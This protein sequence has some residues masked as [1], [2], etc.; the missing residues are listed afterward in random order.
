MFYEYICRKSF[1]FSIGSMACHMAHLR[2]VSVLFSVD[3]REGKCEGIFNAL[4]RI[5][6]HWAHSNNN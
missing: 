6:E 4:K 2:S 5:S 3:G 1:Y